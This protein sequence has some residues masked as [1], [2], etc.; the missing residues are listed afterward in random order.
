MAAEFQVSIESDGTIS[1][2]TNRIPDELHAEADSAIA[3]FKELLGGSCERI[4]KHG[5]I[6]HTH[7][8]DKIHT[9]LHETDTPH[10]H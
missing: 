7:H 3:L 5:K 8:H 10:S 2:D 9:H 6:T 1:I 4:A